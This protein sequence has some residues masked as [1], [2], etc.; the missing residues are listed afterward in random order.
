MKKLNRLLVSDF[1]AA[2]LPALGII[3]VIFLGVAFYGAAY[4]AFQNL[5]ASY[6]HS[7][8]LLHFA[9]FTVEVA[10]APTDTVQALESVPGVTEVSG[11]LVVELPLYISDS[12][13]TAIMARVIS[14]PAPQHP[15]VNDVK[16]ESGSYPGSENTALVLVEKNFADYHRLQPGDEI[17]FFV[18]GSY[19][20]FQIAGTVTSPEY[21]FAAKSRQELL[22]SP[23]TF[24]VVFMPQQSLMALT[25]EGDFNQF[26]FIVSDDNRQAV[27]SAVDNTL[28]PYGVRDTITREEQPSNA[29]LSLDL[30]E[31][32]EIADVFPLLFL[33]IGGLATYALLTRIVENQRGRIGM[34]RSLGYSRRQVLGHYLGFALMIGL[35]GGLFGTVAGYFLSVAVT[36]LYVTILGLPYTLVQLH[37][38]TLAEGFV[39]AVVF[40]L[41][42][43]FLPAWVA[44]RLG[45]AEAMRDP[46][47]VK[48]HRSLAE[49]VVPALGRLPPA[50]KLPLRNVFRNRNRSLSIIAGVSFGI[51]LILVSAAFIDS[52]DALVEL[53]FQKI[54]RYDAAIDFATP[55]PPF[56][57]SEIALWEGV[58]EAQPVLQVPV[59][60]K[61][62]GKSYS[63]LLFGL[64]P[65]NR[66]F[67]L[68]DTSGNP[69]EVSSEILLAGSMRPI[70]EVRSGD[71]IELT[72]PS[73]TAQVTVAGFV[74]QPVG[75]ASYTSLESA[76]SLFGGQDDINGMMVSLK[77]GTDIRGLVAQEL[78]GASVELTSESLQ[79]VER[80]FNLI[81]AIMWVMMSFGALL[82]LAI[83]FTLVFLSITERRREIASM[84]TLGESKSRVFGILTIEDL[85]LGILGLLPG[86]ALGYGLAV[87]FFSI[88]QTDL[89][90]FSMVIQMRTY[91]LISVAMLAIVMLAQIPAIRNINRIDMARVIKEQVT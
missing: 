45:P 69:V 1:L 24:G 62:E 61:F 42:A 75:S 18:D 91:F 25:G 2:K 12:P 9:D 49:R 44:S 15:A 26:C 80:L 41:A 54:Q 56:L 84:R 79:S 57:T 19:Q 53:Q 52:T 78:P 74:E 40:C 43:G 51:S 17:R 87:Y 7:Y 23:E 58:T 67:R 63:T 83:L 89:I 48:G 47:Q 71:S 85:L 64:E 46:P 38:L 3:L 68:F 55:Q 60:L 90:S 88:F 5:K 29:A 76:Q 20:S 6:D 36:R 14:V 59:Q 4:M 73:G 39:V 16:L 10:A 30:Q 8:E 31:F 28:S 32:G 82:A 22:A 21:I 33:F 35:A 77:K 11:R 37:P 13:G 86:L 50:L 27:A 72:M 34:M 66:L 65:G 81:K 70:L